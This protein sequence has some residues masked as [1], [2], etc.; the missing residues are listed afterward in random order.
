[1]EPY[2][3]EYPLATERLLLRPF[4]ASDFDA[5]LAT[6]SDPAVV[7]WLYDEP[8][9][10]EDVRKLLERRSAMLAIAREGDGLGLVL[11][12]R[13]TGEYVGDCNLQLVSERHSLAELGFIVAPPHQGQGYATEA[14]RE[15]L[16]IAFA[17]LRVHRVIGRCEARNAASAAVLER[18]GMRR[19]AHLVE[20][21]WVKEEWQSELVYALLEHEWS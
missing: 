11:E 2:A 3:P 19:E 1:V 8:A 4:A 13:T 18:L 10:G 5:V 12:H 15:L 7:R 21:E 16:R 9:Y 17:E 6:R 14:A 20:N